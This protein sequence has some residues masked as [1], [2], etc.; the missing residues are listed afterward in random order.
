MKNAFLD[1][2]KALVVDNRGFALV[3]PFLNALAKMNEGTTS[4]LMSKEGLFQRAFLCPGIC[5]RAFE[6]TTNVVGLDA[7]HIKARYGGVLLVMTVLDGNGQIFPVAVGIAES[8]NTATWSWFLWLVQSALHINNGGEGLVCLSDR[9][10]GIEN[11][12]HEVS[13][14]QHTACASSTFRRTS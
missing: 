13:P 7:C 11:A 3:S 9:E 2:K 5:A 12:L 6:H 1:V 14:A 10:K 4:S 8:E